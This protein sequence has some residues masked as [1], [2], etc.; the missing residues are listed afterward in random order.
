MSYRIG[1]AS[2]P[3]SKSPVG[4]SLVVHSDQIYT[5]KGILGNVVS[6]QVDILQNHH[7]LLFVNLAAIRVSLNHI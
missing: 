2:F 5:G 1:A 4:V 7:N 3:S 6:Q